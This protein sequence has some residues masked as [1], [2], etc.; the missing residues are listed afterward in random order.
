MAILTKI[1]EGETFSEASSEI[2]ITKQLQPVRQ[3]FM[4]ETGLTIWREAEQTYP[5]YS[6]CLGE[7]VWIST[8]EEFLVMTMLCVYLYCAS[9]RFLCNVI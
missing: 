8:P 7:F 3:R 4:K 6:E 5:E 9:I 1:K 2:K